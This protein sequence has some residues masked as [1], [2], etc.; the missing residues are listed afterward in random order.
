MGEP[1]FGPARLG[2][3]ATILG[4][5][6]ACGGDPVAPAGDELGE[7]EA[8]AIVEF[9]SG[10]A[11]D[12]WSFDEGEGAAASVAPVPGASASSE[13]IQFDVS[14]DASSQC[15]QGGSVSVAGLFAG[16]IDSETETG[17]VALG[18]VVS[19]A[20]C[21]FPAEGTVFT[22]DTSPDL[23]LDGDF[24]WEAGQP[25][26]EQIFSYGGTVLWSA[27]DGR[28]GSCSIDLQVTRA[29]DGTLLE[30]GT[31][32]GVSVGEL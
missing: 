15:P 25:V 4:I 23:E 11:F 24:A 2:L 13:P 3:A 20:A 26:G 10:A 21:S 17:T 30:S 8:A 18:I 16:T 28:S 12:G 19:A 6:A 9:I 5:L 31:A 32:C 27:E 29:E 22:V 14:I 7:A 1:D